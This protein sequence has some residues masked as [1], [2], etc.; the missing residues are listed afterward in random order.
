MASPL[1]VLTNA[2]PLALIAVA[3]IQWSDKL[4]TSNKLAR[5]VIPALGWAVVVCSLVAIAKEL[6]LPKSALAPGL[7]VQAQAAGAASDSISH[8]T[9]WWARRAV[10]GIY[11]PSGKGAL[12]AVGWCR[13]G[14]RRRNWPGSGSRRG[15]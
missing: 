6:T 3:R 14:Y 8:S 15:G 1:V 9:S 2:L 7:T 11:P 10:L 13:C 12:Q 4:S 5:H